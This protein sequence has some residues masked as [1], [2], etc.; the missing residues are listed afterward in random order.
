VNEDH[1]I[2]AKIFEKEINCSLK[3]KVEKLN[4]SGMQLL[5]FLVTKAHKRTK[6]PK[7]CSYKYNLFTFN[8]FGNVWTSHLGLFLFV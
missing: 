2:I 6:A 5:I 3:G 4:P 7:N 8:F 1:F